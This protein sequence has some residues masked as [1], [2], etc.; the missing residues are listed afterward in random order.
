[1]ATANLAWKG[2]IFYLHNDTCIIETEEKTVMS[3]L[4]TVM[5]VRVVSG[6]QEEMVFIL[7]IELQQRGLLHIH[8][9]LRHEQGS[10]WVD[11]LS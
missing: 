6:R 9:L 11:I 10:Y 8:G 1:M 5:L 2:M 3:N 7:G 4:Q